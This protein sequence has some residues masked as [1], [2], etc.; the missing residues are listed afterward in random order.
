MKILK[1]LLSV[2]T[3]G[4]MAFTMLCL[5]AS[6]ANDFESAKLVD[7]GKKVS[8]TCKFEKS[9]HGFYNVLCPK[10]YKV[11]LSEKGTLKLD[12][13]SSVSKLRIDV[14]SSDGAEIYEFDEKNV[15]SGSVIHYGNTGTTAHWNKN[16]RKAK[17][18][19]KYNLDKGTYYVKTWAT[20]GADIEGKNSISFS[21]PQDK[22]EEDGKISYLSL[23]MEKG[24]TLKLGAV[25]EGEGTVKW[26][27]SKSSVVSVTSDG[28]ITA[29]K[30]GTATI[31]AKLGS[32]TVKLKIK[33]V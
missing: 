16:L 12:F 21:Y 2:L 14:I 20:V 32:S 4:V 29:K 26:S 5:P 13:I 11:E 25:I 17:F 18:T 15:T 27:S 3:A 23:E 33:V 19:L 31:I 9:K 30:K 1:K 6:A 7:S 8:Y 10:I 22:N 24:D 28:K